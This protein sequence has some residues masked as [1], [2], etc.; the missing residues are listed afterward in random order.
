M[1]K[2]IW[3]RSP[4]KR[5]FFTFPYKEKDAKRLVSREGNQAK[6]EEDTRVRIAAMTRRVEESKGEAIASLID[7]VCDIKPQVHKNYRPRD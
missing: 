2:H 1:G 6:I 7:L 3:E 4:K 5:F